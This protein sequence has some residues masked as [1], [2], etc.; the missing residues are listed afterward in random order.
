MQIVLKLFLLSIVLPTLIWSHSI[1]PLPETV[2]LDKDKVALGKKLFMD[3]ILSKDKSIACVSCHDLL[4]GGDDGM[5]FSIGIDGKMGDINAPTVYN[6]SHNFR[7]FWDGR[8]K[9][10]EE[11][12]L[13]PIENP[14]EMGATL[15]L[16][17]KRL[18][19][20]SY[21]EKEFNRLYKNGITI[22]SLADAIS[23]FEQALITPNSPFD[24]YLK[25]DKS[26]LNQKEKRGFELFK[27]KGC[28]IC[29]QGMSIGGNL[30]NK[31]GIYEDINLTHLGR[32]NV[33][34][35]EDDKYVFKV[36][37]LRNIA[38]TAPYMHDGRAETLEEA[39]RLMTKH[40]L[41]RHITEEEME[42]LVSFLNTLTGIIPAI[43]K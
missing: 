14:L 5:K 16:V 11:Q 28:I 2:S 43:A 13:G 26:A 41:G 42:A 33:T 30:Y 20:D 22:E 12:A 24:R 21:Y 40:Q 4:N 37:S 1:K 38:L 9:S 25:G 3:P 27:S 23:T 17:L 6:S 36:P 29:H 35:R 34:H 10:L 19:K 15:E 39:V 31:F 18:K 7:Q 32:F 8:A